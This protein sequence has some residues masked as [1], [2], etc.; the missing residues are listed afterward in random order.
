L[1][2]EQVEQVVMMTP[3]YWHLTDEIHEAMQEL[4]EIKTEA[5]FSVMVFRRM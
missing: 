4:E 2:R 3:N 1:N 5:G